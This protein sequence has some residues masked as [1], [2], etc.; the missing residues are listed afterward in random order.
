MADMDMEVVVILEGIVEATGL[1]AQALWSYRKNEIVF[2]RR[3]VPMVSRC[4]GKWEVDFAK[5]DA[6]V[7]VVQP[8]HQGTEA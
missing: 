5:L 8:R 7:P 1:T 3:F 6:T 2:N 4:N